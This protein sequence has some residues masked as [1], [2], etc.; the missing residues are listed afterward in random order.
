MYHISQLGCGSIHACTSTALVGPGG[1]AISA[2]YII[3]VLLFRG[4]GSIYSNQHSSSGSRGCGHI[5]PQLLLTGGSGRNCHCRS[6]DTTNWSWKF[7]YSSHKCVIEREQFM[8]FFVLF[9]K[10]VRSELLARTQ[11]V[12]RCG[13]STKYGS[14][15]KGVNCAE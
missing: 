5:C 15:K 13:H 11:C 6:M 8:F 14:N 4:R 2:A 3:F 7:F 12:L 9:C 1:V 10:D